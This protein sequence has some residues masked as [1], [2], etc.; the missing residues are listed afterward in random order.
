LIASA[1]ALTVLTAAASAA[2]EEIEITGPISGACRLTLERYVVP[3][4]AEWSYWIAS[5][6]GDL[7]QDRAERVL[8]YIGVGGEITTGVLEYSGFPSRPERWTSRRP[9]RQNRAELRIGPW[10]AAQTRSAG[11][12]LEA[13]LTA[14]LGTTDDSL[15]RLT[16]FGVFDLRLGAGYGAFVDERSPYAMAA[17]AWGIR[18]VF[19]RHTWGGACDPVPPPEPVADATLV[20]IVATARRAV[21]LPASEITIGLELSPTIAFVPMRLHRKRFRPDK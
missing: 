12:L 5:G 2:S 11:G 9:G 15:K 20:R 7:R 10:A 16:S 19:E 8:P 17:L 1:A 14:H 3:A 6:V 21:D 13:G 18:T 4:S